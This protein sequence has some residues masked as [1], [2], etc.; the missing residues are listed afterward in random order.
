VLLFTLGATVVTG[1]LC[2]LAPAWQIARGNL[3]RTLRDGGRGALDQAQGKR[4]RGALVIAE[5]AL[6]LIVLTGAGL[7]L[8][9]FHRLLNVDAGFKAENL[10]TVNLGLGDIKDTTR[11]TSVLR[12]V[13]AR[14]A[15]TPGVQ[16]ASSSSALPPINAQ[17]ATRFA[18]QGVPIKK[19]NIAYFIA[20]NPD[21]FRALGTPLRAG[22][23][24]TERDDDKAAKTVIVNEHLARTW[25]PNESALGKR[26]QIINSEYTNEWR[27]IV[28]IVA[29][30]RY[31]G[32]EDAFTATIYTPFA[33]TPFQWSYLMIRTAAPPA[34]LIPSVRQAIKSADPTLDPASFRSLSELVSESVAQPRFY[35]FLLGTFAGL[36]LVLASVGIYGV[37]AYVVTQRTREIG[38]RLAL[39]AGRGAVLRMVLRQGMWLILAGVAFGLLGAWALT[40]LLKTMLFEVSATDPATFLAIT[41]LLAVVALLACWIPARRATKVDPMIAL[42]CD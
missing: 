4:L 30:V 25:F 42:R 21:Y 12:D 1:L 13:L 19:N 32:L 26:L 22:R 31:S 16:T 14:I 24:F 40:R 5:V 11:R 41:L 15:Q 36:A 3:N 34:P 2:G 37:L 20:I 27:E 29:N 10:L 33:Q 6:S 28:G 9:S 18:A 23:E 39:G 35:T 8:K 38:I 7:L 17:R